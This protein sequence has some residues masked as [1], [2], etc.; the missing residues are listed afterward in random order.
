RDSKLA[1]SLEPHLCGRF[2]V[3]YPSDPRSLARQRAFELLANVDRKSGVVAEI[4]ALELIV[5]DNHD[6]VRTGFSKLA[7]QDRE[8]FLNA[9]VFAAVRVEVVERHV[10]AQRS[11]AAYLV[12]VL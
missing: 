6:H 5:A 12:P 2:C 11:P 7:A 4:E 10:R 8:A 9:R 1:L 3:P